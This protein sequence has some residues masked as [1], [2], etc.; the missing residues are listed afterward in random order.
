MGGLD[1]GVEYHLIAAVSEVADNGYF[2]QKVLLI[3]RQY[4]R[5]DRKAGQY[6][7]AG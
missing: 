5:A 1:V 2:G 6:D 7:G 3:Q 4:S